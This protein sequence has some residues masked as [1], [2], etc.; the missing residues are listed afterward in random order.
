VE[1]DQASLHHIEGFLNFNGFEKTRRQDYYNSEF[2]LALEDM[3]DEN[4]LA[5]CEV[6]LPC[7][8]TTEMAFLLYF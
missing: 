8:W 1:G 6:L 4:V 5:K 3:H 7:Q 2:G